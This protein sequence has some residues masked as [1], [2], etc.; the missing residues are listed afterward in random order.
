M[1]TFTLVTLGLLLLSIG[2]NLFQAFMLKELDRQLK[3]NLP[4]F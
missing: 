1:I 2:Y 4:P 3:E